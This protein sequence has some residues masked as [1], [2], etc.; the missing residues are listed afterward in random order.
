MTTSAIGYAAALF[1]VARE[2]GRAAAVADDL[3]A[4]E[5]LLSR[6]ARTFHD[7]QVKAADKAAYLRELLDGGADTLTVQFVVLLAQRKRLKHLPAIRR[8]Y[9]KLAAAALGRTAVRLSA[10]YPVNDGLLEGLHAH[11]AR[12]G[13]CSPD[14]GSV[15]FDVIVDKD[16]LGGFVAESQGRMLDMSLKTRLNRLAR[17]HFA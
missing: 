16:L 12:V 4:V 10:P 11:L 8:Q 3:P 5:E 9:D 1:K 2:L 15:R 13:L 6:F 17:T 7:P 14:M